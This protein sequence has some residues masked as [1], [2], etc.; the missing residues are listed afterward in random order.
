[1]RDLIRQAHANLIRDGAIHAFPNFLGPKMEGVVKY[2][3]LLSLDGGCRLPSGYFSDI[4]R[5]IPIAGSLTSKV[6]DFLEKKIEVHKQIIKLFRDG[7]TPKNIIN[8]TN[9]LHKEL[10]L[11]PTVFFGHH[12]G[13]EIHDLAD[14]GIE[15]YEKPLRSGMV[16]TYEP[17]AKDAET[18]LVCHIENDVLVTPNGGKVLDQLPLDF[19][20]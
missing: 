7:N 9:K 10:G 6:K 12:L 16:L 18:G 5:T 11:L 4:G 19:L 17:M 14:L 1:M 8:E 13:L 2:G 3:D 15:L 20:W